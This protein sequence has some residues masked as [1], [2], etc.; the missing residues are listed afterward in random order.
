MCL[1]Q[2][3]LGTLFELLI[4]EWLYLVLYLVELMFS[5]TP[6]AAVNLC[7]FIEGE[8]QYFFIAA[9]DLA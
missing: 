1:K 3:H 7:R 9:G 5:G 6:P 4:N 8:E 2:I